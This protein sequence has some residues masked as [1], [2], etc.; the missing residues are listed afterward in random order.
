MAVRTGI[1]IGTRSRSATPCMDRAVRTGT[2]I[3]RDLPRPFIVV[4]M[5]HPVPR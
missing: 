2:T 5:L 1:P 4:L 3:G